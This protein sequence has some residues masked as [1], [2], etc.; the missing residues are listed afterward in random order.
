MERVTHLIEG[1]ETPYGMELL[2]TVLWLSQEDP[3]VKNDYRAA[4]RG[5]ETWNQR[6]REHFRPEHIQIAWDRLHEQGWL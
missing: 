6:K 4:V 3:V 2:A 5:F 1:F